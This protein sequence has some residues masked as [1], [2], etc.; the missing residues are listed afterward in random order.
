MLA[1][2]L[3]AVGDRDRPAVQ[4]GLRLRRGVA[5]GAVRHHDRVDVLD[6]LL[7]DALALRPPRR[8]DHDL[9]AVVLGRL[10]ELRRDPVGARDA[11]RVAIRSVRHARG[12]PP[13]R[14]RTP[15]IASTR[16]AKRHPLAEH[17]R[18]SGPRATARRP[19]RTP[20]RPTAS[21][22][23]SSQS[24]WIS[25]PGLMLELDG[26]AVP[27]GPAGLAHRP[28]PE[29]AQLPHQRRVGAIEPELDAPRD[30]STVAV[31]VR[32][33]REPRHQVVAKRLQAARRRLAPRR[34]AR[35]GTCGPSCG[36]GRCAARSQTPTSPAAPSAWISTSSSCVSIPPGP[37][38]DRR[39]ENQRPWRGPP[40]DRARG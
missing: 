38:P 3:A 7:D 8:A 27:A 4:V 1:A 12:V 33:I 19:A 11:R 22:C 35:P 36:P 24:N 40:T 20:A 28:Q 13:R 21:R 29:P 30:S 18:G 16:C 15:S 25:S 34:R 17:A 9:D 37:P 2:A 5:T 23:S 10:R 32:V 31:D 39:L 14:R 6:R 26:H